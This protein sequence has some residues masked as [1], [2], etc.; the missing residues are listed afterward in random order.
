MSPFVRVNPGDPIQSAQLDQ[1]LDAWT[2]VT[3]KGV[4][5][6]LTAL[7]DPS[8]YA[9]TVQN[10]EPTNSRALNV[11]KS[12]GTVLLQANSSGLTIGAPLH[13]PGNTTIDGTLSV[14]GSISTAGGLSAQG[15]I[16]TQGTLTT[17]G[18]ITARQGDALQFADSNSKVT[19]TGRTTYF[20][21]FNG[22]WLWRDSSNSFTAAMTLTHNGTLTVPQSALIQFQDS[23]SRIGSASRS[24][25]F[26]EFNGNW[27]WRNS[28]TG[29][30]SE[31]T[32]SAGGALTLA[33]GITA[34]G[35][36]SVAGTFTIG[37]D[38]TFTRA[39][40]NIL[41][42]PG[43]S[44]PTGYMLG[45]NGFA[46]ASGGYAIGLP[47]TASPAGA[48]IAFAWNLYSS[49]DHA[50]QFGLRAQPISDPVA[51]LKAL[52]PVSYDHTHIE[53]GAAEPVLDESGAIA[54][55]PSYGISATEV[56]SVL[57]ELVGDSS[58]D[59]S[60]LV[61]VLWAATQVLEQRISALEA[62]P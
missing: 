41:V 24:T 27:V 52:H 7:S 5:M 28:A 8:N 31:M 62:Q 49:V 1:I 17:Q 55:T 59:Y 54:S 32:L 53:L 40:T 58:I 21:E 44:I 14:G 15:S 20:D 42:S 6:A 22:S 16:T 10:L 35:N 11:L 47:N 56:A 34:A 12:D 23:N 3:A 36:S 46:Y 60:R 2:G 4:P 19:S 39:A 37:A 50:A 13:V 30:S 26:D 48:G 33:G 51:K 25:Y 38:A 29:L 18:T 61:V 9:L 43:L 57:P 45:V